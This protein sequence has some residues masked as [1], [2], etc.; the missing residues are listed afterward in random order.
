MSKRDL[1]LDLLSAFAAQRPGLEFGNYGDVS[2]YRSEVRAIT[3]DLHTFRTLLAA[4]TW[5][6][7]IGEEE[8]RAAFRNAFSGRLT[9]TDRPDGS[10]TL[11]YCT[12][13]YF[14]TEYRKAA[15]A[16]LAS[17]LWAYQRETL[18]ANTDDRRYESLGDELRQSFR[19]EFGRGIASRYFQ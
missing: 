18:N 17:A 7:S 9:L 2:A 8:L 12:G 19:K 5:R 15:C 11:D 3:K 4:V 6:T 16:V 1:I 14:P 13:Q 10:V